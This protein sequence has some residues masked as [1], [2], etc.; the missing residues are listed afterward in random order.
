L[1][2]DVLGRGLDRGE[3][4]ERRGIG[5][6]VELEADLVADAVELIGRD[7]VVLA[8]QGDDLA[9]YFRKALELR[10][11]LAD[12]LAARG[13][14]RGGRRLGDRRLQ[15]LFGRLGRGLVVCLEQATGPGL[16]LLAERPKTA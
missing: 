13:A 16:S 12:L 11:E 5:K 4:G 2:G 3:P 15:I 9:E 1:R 8:R 14:G 10:L 6:V 7:L